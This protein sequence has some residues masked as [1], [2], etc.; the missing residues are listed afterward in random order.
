MRFKG[1]VAQRWSGLAIAALALGL[2]W[3]IPAANAQTTAIKTAQSDNVQAELSY[4]SENGIE[5]TN[6]RLQ[7]VRSG[8]TVMSDPVPVDSEYDRPLID[9]DPEAFQVRDLDGDREP[10]ILLDF[11]TGGAHCCTY[12]LIYRYESE[13]NQYSPILHNWGNRGYR[14]RELNGDEGT[15]EFLSEDDRFAY[16]F[17]AYAASAYPLR[18]WRYQQGQME[19]TTHEFPDLIYQRAVELW[20]GFEEQRRNGIDPSGIGVRGLLAAYLA[21]KHQLEQGED[22]WQRV[23]TVY[24]LSDRRQFFNHLSQFLRRTGYIR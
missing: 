18:I 4:Q 12:S 22:G 23:L 14:L 19:E 11:F 2:P 16:E 17:T 9:Y 5:F 13:R 20:Q 24:R 21:S 3:Q 10:E 7:V 8:T 6:I 1:S 15:P